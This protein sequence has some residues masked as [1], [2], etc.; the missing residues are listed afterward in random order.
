MT[1]FIQYNK[2][3]F[4]AIKNTILLED[5]I[6]D[7]YDII[8][9]SHDCFNNMIFISIV[10]N[11]KDI[12]SF[13]KNIVKLNTQDVK[14]K[15][16]MKPI[17]KP[18]DSTENGYIK[19]CKSILNIINDTN[20]T[21]QLSKLKFLIDNDNIDEIIE[22]IVNISILQVFYIHIFVKLLTDINQN[23]KI[24][25]FLNEY[26]MSYLDKGFCYNFDNVQ[27]SNE[28]DMFCDI[29]KHKTRMISTGKVM[30]IYIHNS[31]CDISKKEFINIIMSNILRYNDNEL[32]I[33]VC[34]NILKECKSICTNIHN[35]I[36]NN[37][38]N[39]VNKD[40]LNTKLLFLIEKLYQ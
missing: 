14:R 13:P 16:F 18:I 17:R 21:K 2:E 40:V 19:K 3:S 10:K 27:S 9:N 8:F 15:I 24:R 30:F 7:K 38:I 33:D 35:E 34:L 31:L 11:K 6:K 36:P 12:G 37:I 26:I 20:Y 1:D 25:K 28:Y 39:I 22:V 23:H 29:Q 4:F 32:I 5:S